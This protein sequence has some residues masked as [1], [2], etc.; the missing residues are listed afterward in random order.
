MY[1][2]ALKTLMKKVRFFWKVCFDFSRFLALPP[3][4]RIVLISGDVSFR[5]E[6]ILY[7]STCPYILHPFLH[8]Y[9]ASFRRFS[10][11]SHPPLHS[12]MH[13]AES[14]PCGTGTVPSRSHLVWYCRAVQAPWPSRRSL[15]A[16]G[17]D[18][19]IHASKLSYLIFPSFINS[20]HLKS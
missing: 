1:V 4:I 19:T 7:Y 17:T 16:A 18:P 15:P 2:T 8:R 12:A 9:T 20:H 6:P 13:S 14:S 3:E 5:G 10:D 11:I